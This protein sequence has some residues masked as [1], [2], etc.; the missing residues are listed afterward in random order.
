MPGMDGF[1][2]LSRLRADQVLKGTAVVMCTGSTY[3]RDVERAETLGAVGYMVKP[4]SLEQLRPMMSNLN[5]LHL[6][7]EGPRQQLLRTA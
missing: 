4:A 6:S 7:A 3:D 5:G 2:T 1:E